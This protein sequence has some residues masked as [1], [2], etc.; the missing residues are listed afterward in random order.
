VKVLGLEGFLVRDD[1]VYPALSRIANFSADSA[2]D[3]DHRAR[4]LLAGPCA[5]PPTAVDQMHSGASGRYMLA[6]A[7]GD[8]LIGENWRSARDWWRDDSEGDCQPMMP[9]T[10]ALKSGAAP[11]EVKLRKTAYRLGQ[12]PNR[13]LATCL[14]CGAAGP[15]NPGG[16]WFFSL[17]EAVNAAALFYK[18]HG[19]Y[20]GLGHSAALSAYV[21]RNSGVYFVSD[22]GPTNARA[23]SIS[24]GATWVILV[25]YQPAGTTWADYSGPRCWVEVLLQSPSYSA[26]AGETRPGTYYGTI[27]NAGDGSQCL[28]SPG[29]RVPLSAQKPPGAPL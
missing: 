17:N 7:L 12:S 1:S 10:G 27:D 26:V 23:V 18:S 24:S 28:A 2:T 13:L 16:G 11:G 20:V 21:D 22:A 25:V 8:R 19:T 3:A 29:L 4:Y 5:A 6:V 9:L 14:G 15:S